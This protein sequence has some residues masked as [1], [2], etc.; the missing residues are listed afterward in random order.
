MTSAP[1]PIVDDHAAGP[2]DPAPG[3]DDV[4]GAAIVTEVGRPVAGLSRWIAGAHAVA[5]QTGR[6]LYVVTGDG[7][8]ITYPLELLVTG[9]RAA[10]WIA[11]PADSHGY[12]D[13]LSGRPVRWDGQ[14]FAADGGG[15][16]AGGDP[17]G[18]DA[19]RDAA[20]DYH[21]GSARAV[22]PPRLDGPGSVR[23]EITRLH[24]A[25]AAEIGGTASAAA[26]ALTGA[27][28]AGWGTGEPAT[29]PWSPQDLTAFARE[30][31]PRPTSVVI[32]AG[33]HP[34]PAVGLLEAEPVSSGVLS[35]VRLAIG[36]DRYPGP[37]LLSA[38]DGLAEALAA[39][40]ARAMLVAWQPGS[41]DGARAP[42][43]LPPSVP[44]GLFAGHEIVSARGVDHARAAP[45]ETTAIVGSRSRKA[46]WCRF[47]TAA[48]HQALVEVMNHFR[49]W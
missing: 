25:A 1:V 45:A 11:R 26:A 40:D 46:C 43:Q 41:A 31:A 15:T 23:V 44:V 35:R 8:R 17:A 29:E 24:P 42:G 32:T 39:E 6:T 47:G 12:C 19:A 13:G 21:A 7:T 22:P 48:P 20:M 30:R 14:R 36:T 27:E 37:Q 38:L 16:P 4:T 28:P 49:K 5:A 18:R 2:D 10:R 34:R 33:T 3:A 9:S